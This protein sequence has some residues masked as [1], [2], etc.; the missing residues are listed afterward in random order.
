M[1]MNESIKESMDELEGQLKDKVI[2]V[3]MDYYQLRLEGALVDE[4][5]QLST[6]IWEQ[7]KET[8]FNFNW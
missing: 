6:E 2:M 1:K 5:K 8:I 3:L 7:I 4:I